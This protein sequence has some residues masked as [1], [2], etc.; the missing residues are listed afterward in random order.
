MSTTK[1]SVTHALSPYPRWIS[2]IWLLFILQGCLSIPVT[3]YDKTTYTNLTRLK[4]ETTQ[5]VKSFDKK[6][7]EKNQ[8]AIEKTQLNLQ[9]AYEYEIGKGDENSNTIKQFKKIMD[10]FDQDVSDYQEGGPGAFGKSYFKETAKI[11][12]KA[13]D[14]VIATENT[15]NQN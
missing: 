1:L 3:H 11:L 7:L 4:A 2:L 8:T 12:G 5:L 13:F 9:I 6:P 14:I 15:K 10:L